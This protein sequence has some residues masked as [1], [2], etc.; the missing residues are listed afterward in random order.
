M[1][2][3]L[4][5]SESEPNVSICATKTTDIIIIFMRKN[6]KKKGWDTK[7]TANGLKDAVEAELEFSCYLIFCLSSV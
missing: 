3:I 5:P 7:V 1:S 6:T 2:L 4:P